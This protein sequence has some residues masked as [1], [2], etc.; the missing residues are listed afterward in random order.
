MGSELKK[1]RIYKEVEAKTL[2][3]ALT[4]YGN[5]PLSGIMVDLIG[6]TDQKELAKESEPLNPK[7]VEGLEIR[8]D[9]SAIMKV[10]V[11][12]QLEIMSE[13]GAPQVDDI[14][15]GAVIQI[16]FGDTPTC[17]ITTTSIV[18]TAISED[19]SY[20]F[21]YKEGEDEGILLTG[22]PENLRSK[23]SST[24]PN[25]YPNLINKAKEIGADVIIT[26]Q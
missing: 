11:L 24:K 14:F 23:V 3:E 10:K 12:E 4:I 21:F 2:D 22:Y 15:K 1:F 6:I 26:H 19:N 16:G 5:D 17:T 13:N 7:S 9:D 25:Q 18:R 8:G 20:I